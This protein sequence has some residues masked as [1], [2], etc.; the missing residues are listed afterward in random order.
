MADT[1]AAMDRTPVVTYLARLASGSD[2]A[3]TAALETIADLLRGGRDDAL[4]FPWHGQRSQHTAAI[5]TAPAER[6]APATTSGNAS[7]GWSW[8]PPMRQRPLTS[9]VSRIAR[10]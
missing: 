8:E 2:R 9:A 1:A 5:R 6:C 3:Q 10:S 7:V 4:A